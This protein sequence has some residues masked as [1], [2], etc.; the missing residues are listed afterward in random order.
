MASSASLEVEVQWNHWLSVVWWDMRELAVAAVFWRYNDRGLCV[1][2]EGSRTEIRLVSECDW[3]FSLS[4]PPKS[5][6]IGIIKQDQSIVLF[7]A[8]ALESMYCTDMYVNSQVREGV[9]YLNEQTF[10]RNQF[11]PLSKRKENKELTLLLWWWCRE[12]DS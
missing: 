6:S 12:I 1:W 4:P 9:Q 7:N 8:I 2:I 11:V 5:L 10:T 3:V